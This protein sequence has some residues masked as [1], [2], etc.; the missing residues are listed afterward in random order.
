MTDSWRSARLTPD[1]DGRAGDACASTLAY[2]CASQYI[3]S[4]TATVHA[5]SVTL[6]LAML[7]PPTIAAVTSVP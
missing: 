6:T 2:T 3:G 7:S 4:V 1:H 5:M